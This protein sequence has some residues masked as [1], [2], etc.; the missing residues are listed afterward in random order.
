MSQEYLNF[1][2]VTYSLHNVEFDFEFLNF[3]FWLYGWESFIFSFFFNLIL[4]WESLLFS[5]MHAWDEGILTLI[6]ITT[7]RWQPNDFLLFEA[8]FLLLFLGNRNLGGIPWWQPR[9]FL[10]LGVSSFRQN[11]YSIIMNFG[12]F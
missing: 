4:K 10:L 3:E 8:P 7:W 2:F 9:D 12:S 5:C 11:P 1:F 6:S